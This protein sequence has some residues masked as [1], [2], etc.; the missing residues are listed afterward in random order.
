MDH[1]IDF[2]NLIDVKRNRYHP[3]SVKLNSQ[4]SNATCVLRAQEITIVV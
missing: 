4:Q 1:V 3:P 2:C